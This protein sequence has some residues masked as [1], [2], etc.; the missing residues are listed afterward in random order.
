MMWIKKKLIEFG[1]RR[2][3]EVRITVGADSWED[4]LRAL[5]SIAFDLDTE[6]V[7][8]I[9]IIS[10]GCSSGWSIFG[11]VDPEWTA[12]RHEEA[13][14]DWRDRERGSLPAMKIP[15]NTDSYQWA[16]K[17]WILSCFSCPKEFVGGDGMRRDDVLAAAKLVGWKIGRPVGRVVRV[18]CSECIAKGGR[19]TKGEEL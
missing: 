15:S 2:N 14:L 5:R 6:R 12:E 1:F 13:I 9:G 7:G 4:F 3:V 10:G 16:R 8:R 19:V 17:T 18:K 11:D